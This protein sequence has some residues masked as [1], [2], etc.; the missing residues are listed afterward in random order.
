MDWYIL[1]LAGPHMLESTAVLLILLR[2]PF[3]FILFCP[4]GVNATV[5]KLEI[6]RD[7]QRKQPKI[8]SPSTV[9]WAKGGHAREKKSRT[10]SCSFPNSVRPDWHFNKGCWIPLFHPQG[11]WTHTFTRLWPHAQIV[12]PDKG[13]WPWLCTVC[14]KNTLHNSTD[15]CVPDMELLKNESTKGKL[16]AL[17]W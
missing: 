11:I 8:I 9:R 14:W 10:A 15:K 16:S 5:N 1:Y 6:K 7:G 17:Q 2:Q 3:T 12:Y 13:L 4:E